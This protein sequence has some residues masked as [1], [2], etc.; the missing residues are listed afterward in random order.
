MAQA[1]ALVR[2]GGLGEERLEEPPFLG[3]ERLVGPAAAGYLVGKYGAEW[4]F[5]LN[6]ASF[7]ARQ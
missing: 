5:Y 3:G 1:D 4:A 7:V 2:N 6:A